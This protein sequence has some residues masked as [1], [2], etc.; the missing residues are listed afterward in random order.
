MAGLEVNVVGALAE[1][2]RD[3]YRRG[4]GE[5]PILKEIIQ[6]AD[7]ARAT[8]LHLVVLDDGVADAQ[9]PLLNGPALVCINNGPFTEEHE[10]ALRY[11]GLTSKAGD[12]TTVGRFGLGQKSVFHLAEA[13]FYLGRSS[14]ESPILA[15]VID[16]WQGP[17]G[18]REKPGW[19][20]F[21]A[22]DRARVQRT[23][24]AWLG[25]PT[26]FALYIPLRSEQHRRSSGSVISQH[27][28]VLSELTRDL[29]DL[30]ELG[31]LLPQLHSVG[32]IESWILASSTGARRSLGH[33]VWTWKEASLSRPSDAQPFARAF[34][35]VM[36]VETS[37]GTRSLRAFGFERC[38]QDAELS[39]LAQDPG[40]PRR[41]VDP[42]AGEDV[43][44][45]AVPHGAVTVQSSADGTPG[46]TL[47]WAVFLPL[48]ATDQ[49]LQAPG[50]R[51]SWR[52][53]LHAYGF[54]DSG[55][56]AF[57]GVDAPTNGDRDRFTEL[58][59]RWN[60]RLL[61][62][63]T[64]ACLLDA[65]A[66]AVE[67]VDADEGENL[68][69]AVV[70]SSFWSHH[71]AAVN[72]AFRLAWGPRAS[73][74]GPATESRPL[75]IFAG[76]RILRI[77]RPSPEAFAGV[78]DILRAWL[79]EEVAA[80][81][82]LVWAESPILGADPSSDAWDAADL[83]RV[84]ARIE[85]RVLDRKPAALAYVADALED[86]ARSSPEIGAAVVGFLRRCFRE[87][88]L[89]V[90]E[91]STEWTR[92]AALCPP[93]TIFWSSAGVT[94]LRELSRERTS[95]LLLPSKLR[96]SS[97]NAAPVVSRDDARTLLDV[98]SAKVRS[99]QPVSDAES[100]IAEIVGTVG[101]AIVLQ[102]PALSMLPLFRVWSA[103]RS[104]Y[105]CAEPA[106]LAALSARGCAFRKKG[107]V[108][109]EQLAKR[110]RACVGGAEADVLLVDDDAVAD[111]MAVPPFD[112][113]LLSRAVLD[114]A[115]H[116]GTLEARVNLFEHVAFGA[117][118]IR[119]AEARARTSVEVRRALRLLIHGSLERAADDTPLLLAVAEVEEPFAEIGRLVLEAV[120]DGWR[121]VVEAFAQHLS[122]GWQVALGIRPLTED[123][124]VAA[125]SENEGPWRLTIGRALGRD[126]CTA[127]AHLLA[128]KSADRLFAS[129]AIHQTRDGALVSSGQAGIWLEGSFPVPPSLGPNVRLIALA[130]DAVIREAQERALHPIWSAE[131]Q[132]K[133]CL[134]NDPARHTRELLD[135][136]ELATL[137]PEL[138]TSLR[139]ARW[140]PTI[141]GDPVPPADVLDV[142]AE[143]DRA[144]RTLLGD[145]EL[146]FQAPGLIDAD[147]RQHRAFPKALD[148][149][150]LRDDEAVNAIAQ[151]LDFHVE[152]RANR[153]W[154]LAAGARDQEREFLARGLAAPCLR[155]DPTWT[156]LA[157]V[158]RWRPGKWTEGAGGRE[159]LTLLRREPSAKRVTELLARFKDEKD[160]GS[161]DVEVSRAVFEEYL[162]YAR[163]RPDFVSGV[164]P[165]IHLLNANKT[166]RATT[167]LAA[168]DAN[169]QDQFKLFARHRQILG[170]P[171]QLAAEMAQRS[172]P[173][174]SNKRARPG[175]ADLKT[176]AETLGKYFAAWAGRVSPEAI[177]Y[178]LACL[179][180]GAGGAFEK[181]AHAYL[182]PSRTV[183]GAREKIV[184]ECSAV[185]IT[186]EFGE[187][188]KASWAV[189]IV[190]EGE[191]RD[192]PSLAGTTL[193]AK[194]A[195]SGLGGVFVGDI[196]SA[197]PAGQWLRLRRVDP[198]ADP[199]ELHQALGASV[200]AFLQSSLSVPLQP[201]FD[202]FWAELGRG[203][204]TQI[205]AVRGLVLE[206]LPVHL[207]ALQLRQDERFRALLVRVDR[208]EQR[209]R[210]R[211]GNNRVWQDAQNQA[212]QERRDSHTTL[213]RTVEEDEDAQRRIVRAVRAKLGHYQY[214]VEQV[215]FELFQNADDAASELLG[216]GSGSASTGEEPA[217][218]IHIAVD[219]AASTLRVEHWGRP[220]NRAG[221]SE[222]GAELSE[223]AYEL[224]LKNML[225]LNLSDKDGA[226]TG[227][228]GLGF[229]SVHLLTHRPRVR[230]GD[231]SFEIVGGI[232]PRFVP[233]DGA[234]ELSTRIELPL[235]DVALAD[236]ALSR[237]TSQGSLLPVFARTIRRL[238]V[239]EDGERRESAWEPTLV[240]G[241]E[242][243]EVGLVPTAL[244]SARSESS[245]L[246]VVRGTGESRRFAI[247]FRVGVAEVGKFAPD[248]AEIW[249]TAPTLEHWG[250]GYCINAPFV[251][252]VGRG[253]LAR[254][255]DD[256]QRMFQQLGELLTNGLR[257]LAELFTADF[258]R[259]VAELGLEVGS[260]EPDAVRHRFWRS[261]FTTLTQLPGEAAPERAVLVRAMHERAGVGAF[262]SEHRV[263]PTGL[264][265]RHEGLTTTR[266]VEWVCDEVTAH[267]EVFAALTELGWLG[268]GV[269]PGKAIHV[270]VYRRLL[271]LGAHPP[272]VT[273]LNF[274]GVLE[275]SIPARTTLTPEMACSLW[276]L[277]CALRSAPQLPG[278]PDEVL[279]AALGA[280]RFMTVADRPQEPSAILLGRSAESVVRELDRKRYHDLGDELRRAEFAP[281]QHVL[282][283]KYGDCPMLELFLFARQRLQRA[284]TS[285]LAHWAADA[286]D[287]VKQRAALAYL[288]SGEQADGMSAALKELGGLTWCR[289]SSDLDALTMASSLSESELSHLRIRCGFPG[290]LA[291]GPVEGFDDDFESIDV[292]NGVPIQDPG[293]V[294]GRISR[295]W[296]ARGKVW[297]ER[298]DKRVYPGLGAGVT[299][300]RDD[301]R[302]GRS[303]AWTLLFT[304]AAC[305]RFG[306]QSYDQHAGFLRRLHE[307]GDPKWWSVVSA[308]PRKVKPDAWM[309]VIDQWLDT[310][311]DSDQYRLW[312]G[313]FPTLYQLHRHG[314]AYRQLLARADHD[315]LA[316]VFSLEAHLAPRANPA[317]VGAGAAFDAPP[318]GP[319]LGIG[320]N[321]ILREL[322]RLEV[323]KRKPHLVPFCYV[324][325]GPLR[326]LMQ[327]L[328]ASDVEEPGVSHG[329]RSRRI[330]SFLA[331][332]LGEDAAFGGA[333]DLP[334]YLYETD[335]EAHREAEVL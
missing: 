306:R 292:S 308:D 171:E 74:D 77:R 103:R 261:M 209:H 119:D 153:F 118:A 188:R 49:I 33:A 61:D 187:L 278:H 165:N 162:R 108:S 244:G 229:K 240:G 62:V 257:Q 164:L 301:L 195:G 75:R 184:Y 151:Q 211:S 323:V 241:R 217:R 45:K 14:P 305:Q 176:A 296:A 280:A 262:V 26:F 214:S 271:C 109:P 277:Y 53:W 255:S 330:H 309:R 106:E 236:R 107:V 275:R 318:L 15:D 290:S 304:I 213:R 141:Q 208:A 24:S 85:P 130:D 90:G 158:D 116:A 207:E 27:F 101:P 44:E 270:D 94:L 123:T 120:G 226:A 43:P 265:G 279:R 96:P 98:L 197:S 21:G 312:L 322:V 221:S 190:D 228:F 19:T 32:R 329:E 252:D 134:A 183:A 256:N 95:L 55:R 189:D 200:R 146:V 169:L 150:A 193:Q 206:H 186:T 222:V 181:L 47:G 36:S 281:P 69:R 196:P 299:G 138:R 155:S 260:R 268:K 324:P 239:V 237:L 166:W 286:T 78:G 179:G 56:R 185:G 58:H 233:Y 1:L 250:L 215:L 8:E 218:Q 4:R 149:L 328:G 136:I 313:L 288:A 93:G 140:L 242:E 97:V 12:H 132:I 23:L 201:A 38:V 68:A 16:P 263:L 333:F 180:D 251:L 267:G 234:P 272:R 163:A 311:I 115:S 81:A 152:D 238:V 3:R 203:G 100:L 114:P 315:M 167:T 224:D 249:C 86:M 298:H 264:P 57:A 291:P 35:G 13:Y 248:Q 11:F 170:A 59:A 243:L 319:A 194:V 65:L 168:S 316:R 302:A 6:N 173:G 66:P 204:Q 198:A 31:A 246:L 297:S 284:G 40:W 127:L 205:E 160:V 52:I 182:H 259:V 92:L 232:V 22:P 25:A 64:L 220:I 87:T 48:G 102:D 128:R 133:V 174:E 212:E 73:A 317:L 126:L 7:D 334:L 235:D 105:I 104:R 28:P 111:A 269:A 71:A 18:D 321:W 145:A 110:L 67:A 178:F 310:R 30:T 63:G 142:P 37:A 60:V 266:D 137:S 17:K 254:N 225:V 129:L 131:E 320:A 192:V 82:T 29:E 148:E 143:V 99:A 282:H 122:R 245:R 41:V 230:S 314:T 135:A 154:V 276:R 287:G 285:E 253:Q 199:R 327:R 177:G 76:R 117:F 20:V 39:R 34:G 147:T 331:Q 295:W 231:L 89:T 247:A 325:R 70:A 113:D 121:V 326:R 5:L 83:E 79:H 223:R 300:L 335:P 273:M 51:L 283:A 9:N 293:V 50:L 307:Q 274:A 156:F 72:G 157:S 202:L 210:E 294:L 139:E 88:V 216:P 42:V 175:Q 144:L 289:R 2:L 332:V 112:L 91:Q 84:L 161:S 227:R 219:R 159:L 124:L 10:N 191:M 125:M 172:A 303:E 46:L 258:A 54:P 80:D